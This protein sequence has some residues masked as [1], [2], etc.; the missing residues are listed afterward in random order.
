MEEPLYNAHT[1]PS[2]N[3]L[4]INMTEFQFDSEEEVKKA[5]EKL[6]KEV[7]DAQAKISRINA[8]NLKA[9]ERLVQFRFC[10]FV[11]ARKK[12]A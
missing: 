11:L 3:Y 4:G 7:N 5:L 9:K 12:T 8:P 1:D 10:R 6:N 2:K